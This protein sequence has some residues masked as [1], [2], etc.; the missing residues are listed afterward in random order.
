MHVNPWSSQSVVIDIT[1]GTR[2]VALCQIVFRHNPGIEL[3][4]DIVAEEI[5]TK[6]LDNPKSGRQSIW[7]LVNAI[8]E[9]IRAKTRKDL[10][11]WTE[12]AFYRMC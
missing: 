12:S 5:D 4:W 8:N 3:S 9:K 11:V 2:Q 7:D 1:S 10:F 6:L